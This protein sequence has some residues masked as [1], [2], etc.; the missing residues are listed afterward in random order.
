GISQSW[1][2]SFSRWFFVLPCITCWLIF[3]PR[4][5]FHFQCALSLMHWLFFHPKYFKATVWF[6]PNRFVQVLCCSLQEASSAGFKKNILLCFLLPA[7]VF[8]YS[9]NLNTSLCYP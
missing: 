5:T 6:W 1:L 2:P 4:D 3:S 8:L 7:F 9:Q